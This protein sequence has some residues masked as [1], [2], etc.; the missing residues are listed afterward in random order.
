M[1]DK[2]KKNDKLYPLLEATKEYCLSLKKDNKTKDIVL[3]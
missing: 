1:T 3:L 2:E